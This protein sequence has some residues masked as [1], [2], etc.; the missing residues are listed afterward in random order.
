ELLD[1]LAVAADRS[2]EP[3]QVAIDHEDQVVELL[4][5]CERDCSQRFGLVHFAVAAEDPDLAPLGV[6][7]S[8]RM[9]ILEE[10]GLVDRLDRTETHRYSGELPELRHQLRVRIRSDA[11]AVDVASEA[12]ELLRGQTS[13]EDPGRVDT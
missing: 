11:L 10:P 4:A 12:V 7:D 1:D 13:F 3:L 9:Q 8:A 2:V 5:R 6:R